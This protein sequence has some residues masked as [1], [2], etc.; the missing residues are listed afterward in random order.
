MYSSGFFNGDDEYGQDEFNRYF[1]NLFE[2]GVGMHADG[3]LHL[4][5]T[6]ME[7]GIHLSPGFAIVKGFYFYNDS[8]LE[9]AVSPDSNY[10]RIDRLVLR[11]NVLTGPVQ[12]LIKSGTAGSSP[13]VPGL[14]RDDSVYELSLARLT[15]QPSGAVTV[16]D[17]RFDPGLCG[18]IRP[19][20]LSELKAMTEEY[21]RKW[22]EWFVRQ[23]AAG[24]RNIF[25]QE[26]E[27][28]EG[29][30]VEGSLWI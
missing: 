17:D 11:L 7:G 28:E 9:M 3:S 18:V 1:E 15:V 14:Q 13:T 5:V 20:N 23:Q 6:P 30:A 8:D 16:A 27:P 25:L 12:P 21:E 2:S 19:R 10:A 26:K 29:E 4:A 24:W 22:D